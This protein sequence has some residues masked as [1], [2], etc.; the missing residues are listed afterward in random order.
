MHENSLEKMSLSN[1]KEDIFKMSKAVF[2]ENAITITDQE[3]KE[4][5][6]VFFSFIAESTG[7]QL[8]DGIAKEMPHALQDSLV[9]AIGKIKSLKSLATLFDAF[10][11]KILV[12]TRMKSYPEVCHCGMMTLY[13]M[14]NI[15]HPLPSID[16]STIESLK[17]KPSGDYIFGKAY[18]TRN[19][20]HDSPNWDMS[21]I[22]N[23]TKYV[24]ALYIFIIHSKKELLLSFYPCLN[25]TK[26]FEY[27]DNKESQT[28]YDFISFSNPTNKIKNQVVNSF[29]SHLLYNDRKYKV[30]DLLCK[31]VNFSDGS[32][33]TNAAQRLIQNL[34]AKKV[35][36]YSDSS[37]NEVIL[38][39][40]EYQRVKSLIAD[41]NDSLLLF[42]SDVD[43]LLEDYSLKIDKEQL[44]KMFGVFFE[45]NFNLDVL[46]ATNQE[47]PLT[48]YEN[49]QNLINYMMENGL[50]F[51]DSKQLFVSILSIC[52]RNDIIV[53]IS[54]GK[55]FSKM[56]NPDLFSNYVRSLSHDVY[57]DTQILLYVLCIN[58]DYLPYD[59]VFYRVG[60]NLV[61]ID[62]KKYTLKVS[63]HYLMEVIFQ[64]RQA[65]FLIQFTEIE[66]MPA[67][68]IST[69]VFYTYFYWLSQNDG[70]P[71]HVGTFREFMFDMFELEERDAF[72]NEY[73]SIAEGVVESLLTENFGIS[74]EPTTRFDPAHL[75]KV[76][77]LYAEVIKKNKCEV[78][79]Y[80][81][82][83]NDAL[84]CMVLFDH[85]YECAEPFFLTW[86][87]SF[88]F[89]VPEY[90]KKY[91]RCSSSLFVHLLSPAKFINHVDLVDFKVNTNTLSDD[92][93][94]LIESNSYKQ[95]TYNIID[96]INGFLDIPEMSPEKRKTYIKIMR[97]EIYK[98]DIFSYELMEIEQ[99]DS[100]DKRSF[101]FISQELFNYFKDKGQ[102]S[103]KKYRTMLLS[104]ESFD[105][106]VKILSDYLQEGSTVEVL[107]VIQNVDALVEKS[108]ETLNTKKI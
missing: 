58:D 36:A 83:Q 17:G 82:L 93:L 5:I 39:E 105:R 73:E 44:I 20:V 76:Q 9:D 48:S 84:E 6:S 54:A 78:K 30:K 53:R 106:F 2:L 27:G 71:D 87:K 12:S 75:S 19:K 60:K 79:A 97:K 66:R 23:R 8:I 7:Q 94:S 102:G 18:L 47:A 38:S 50:S 41:Y 67:C 80:K 22:V 95:T 63:S 72:N 14:L 25:E 13:K 16:E 92:L 28:V 108:N 43:S 89:M 65:L 100:T 90:K 31:V 35:L 99:R 51:E 52:R 69:N 86:D 3:L 57:L 107:N 101:A 68:P 103:T 49:Y 46:E 98:G 37:R 33:S 40:V 42:N 29:V 34:I 91:R 10:A 26:Q 85:S 96:T 32:L 88:G 55:V 62:K 70:L 15:S 81:A 56:S 45:N 24:V 4:D 1:I 11:K 59:N 77:D 104:E 64:L 21:E 74:I 61:D